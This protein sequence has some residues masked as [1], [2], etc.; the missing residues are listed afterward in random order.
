RS[1]ISGNYASPGPGGGVCN[2]GLTLIGNSSISGN[3]AT[4]FGGGGIYTAPYAATGLD[5]STVTASV[6]GGSYNFV[7]FFALKNSVVAGNIGA[8]D[9]GNSPQINF[10]T[11]MPGWTESAGFNL[12]GSTN[13]LIVPGLSDQFNVTAEALRLGPL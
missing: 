6:G 12:I 8:D 1:T 4:V 11:L 9:L 10:F 2:D 7:G 3:V 13:G 5:N